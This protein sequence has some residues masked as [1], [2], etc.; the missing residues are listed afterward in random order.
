[1][2]KWLVVLIVSISGFLILGGIGMYGVAST[3]GEV[4]V[5]G[6]ASE[7]ITFE[8]E[9]DKYY[10]IFADDKEIEISFETS[11]PHDPELTYLLRCG[12]DDDTIGITA[13]CGDKRESSYLVADFNTVEDLGE[14]TLIFDGSGE[15]VIVESS[16]YDL[17]G[18][19][20]LI[21]T[22]CCLCP[23]GMIVSGIKLARGKPSG[24]VII[25][26]QMMH[27]PQNNLQTQPDIRII[28]SN[29]P[30]PSLNHG[31]QIGFPSVNTPPTHTSGGYEWLNTNDSM[32]FREIGSQGN[33]QEFQG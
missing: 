17:T 9:W 13:S 14:V 15:V 19:L 12:E 5:K 25:G 29:N 6:D 31:Q 28:Q 16:L 32:Y 30:I 24:V 7:S 23:I 1:M 26:N 22:G 27:Q 2:N 18:W 3:D 20:T 21:C 11:N 8:P 33:W 4:V 10:D